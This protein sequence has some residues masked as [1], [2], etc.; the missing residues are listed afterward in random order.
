L[1]F[2]KKWGYRKLIKKGLKTISDIANEK[3][4]GC[5]ACVNACPVKCI[6]VKRDKEGFDYPSINERSCIKCGKCYSVCPIHSRKVQRNKPLL[7]AMI[8]KHKKA[9]MESSSGGVF[10]TLAKNLVK[11]GGKVCAVTI[12]EKQIV[13]HIIIADE[14]GIEKCM[15]SKYVQSDLGK[16]FIE[17]KK[18]LEMGEEILFVG[19]PCQVYGLYSFLGKKYENL[20][21]VD[22][23]CHGVPSPEIWKEYLNGMQNGSRIISV[24]FRDMSIEGWKNFG[25]RIT[26]ENYPDYVD[27]QTNNIFMEGF[28]RGY[29]DRKSCYNCQFKG[30]YRASDLTLG[31]FWSLHSF[32]E[33]FDDNMGTSLVYVNTKKGKK[34]INQ[35]KEDFYIRKLPKGC[36]KEANTAYWQSLNYMENRERFYRNYFRGKSMKEI[37][38][39]E[40]RKHKR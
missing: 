24:S 5:M 11:N 16:C 36:E 13:K 22:L 35:V 34:M 2:C 10:Y 15:R 37:M 28:L 26:Y 17:I 9:R 20:F 23:I 19:T 4:V 32:F 31:D 7:L 18:I 8:N 14:H 40:M 1:D 12:D 38:L 30:Y 33:D 3:C 6:Y 39:F 25:M 29:Y 27:V 21:L